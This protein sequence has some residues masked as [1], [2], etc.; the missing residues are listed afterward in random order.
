MELPV[1]QNTKNCKTS[2]NMAYELEQCTVTAQKENIPRLK[3]LYNTNQDS[4]FSKKSSRINS[5]SVENSERDTN[6]S[7]QENSDI[8]SS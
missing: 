1:F 5:S 7:F 6:T 3:D 4:L 2:N 8:P